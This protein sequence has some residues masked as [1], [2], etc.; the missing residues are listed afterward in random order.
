MHW[1]RR[2]M[3]M[4]EGKRPLGKPRHKLE[5]NIKTE[6]RGLG[7]DDMNWIHL[8]EDRGQLRALVSI[9]M[10]FGFHEMWGNS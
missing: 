8:A 6:L 3:H 9:V 2:G 1:G 4:P 10:N 5:D 7:W